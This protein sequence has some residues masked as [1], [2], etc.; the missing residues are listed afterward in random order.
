MQL[1]TPVEPQLPDV[2]LEFE[3]ELD[4][5]LDALFTEEDVRLDDILLV[6]PLM[7]LDELFEALLIDVMLLELMLDDVA[8]LD[9]ELTLE[10]TLELLLFATTLDELL[11]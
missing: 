11:A 8:T 5:L 1:T 10:A 2:T 3:V 4:V 6:D 7:L 9:D